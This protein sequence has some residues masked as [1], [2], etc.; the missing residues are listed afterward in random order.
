MTVNAAGR[1]DVA[2]GADVAVLV[3]DDTK[4]HIGETLE[5]HTVKGATVGVQSWT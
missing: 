3:T 1:L 4:V 5:L 2:A